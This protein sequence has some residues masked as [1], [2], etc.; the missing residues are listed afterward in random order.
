MV[1]SQH[2][3]RL[4]NFTNHA[5]TSRP[6]NFSLQC[7]S[8][9]RVKQGWKLNQPGGCPCR[10]RLDDLWPIRKTDQLADRFQHRIVGFFTAEPLDAL[11]AGDANTFVLSCPQLKKV[12]QC[13]LANASL[14]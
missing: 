1:H 14:T 5:L 4:A 6:L 7:R 10:K 3:Q 8:L 2:F 9:F 11:S 12:Y 13:G